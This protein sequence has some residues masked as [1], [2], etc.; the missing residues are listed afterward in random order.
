MVDLDVVIAIA[1]YI[2]NFTELIP[3]NPYQQR[4]VCSLGQRGVLFH[5]GGYTFN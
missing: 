3:K 2:A 4:P 5:K 1:Y